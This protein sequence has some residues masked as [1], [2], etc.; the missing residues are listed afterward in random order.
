[1]PSRNYQ[2]AFAPNPD[3]SMVFSRGREIIG[4]DGTP[5]VWP[6]EA[7]HHREILREPEAGDWE[8]TPGPAAREP[9]TA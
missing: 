5:S 4:A 3:W 7:S 8:L 9:T 2:Y 1:M 6:Y